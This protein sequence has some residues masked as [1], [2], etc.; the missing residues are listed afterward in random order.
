MN[1]IFIKLLHLLFLIFFSS[2]PFWPKKYL[3][4]GMFAPLTLATVWFI[5]EGC[6]LTMVDKN[7]NDED[8]ITVI[9]HSLNINLSQNRIRYLTY[10]YMLFITLIATRKYYKL[11]KKI[12]KY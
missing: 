5:F 1:I 7:L 4:Y 8:F 3:K 6:P 10:A 11:K 9:V 2:I 12:E